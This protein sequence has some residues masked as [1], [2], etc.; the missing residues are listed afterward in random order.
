MNF[1]KY[2]TSHKNDM[3]YSRVAQKLMR[4]FAIYLIFGLNLNV[5][6]TC[7]WVCFKYFR[8]ILTTQIMLVSTC[9][10]YSDYFQPNKHFFVLPFKEIL[11]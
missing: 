7:C 5:L 3:Q 10:L 9:K 1:F 4:A 8:G 6:N 11:F 2:E